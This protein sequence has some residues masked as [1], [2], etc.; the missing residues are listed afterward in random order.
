MKIRKQRSEYNFGLWYVYTEDV[1]ETTVQDKKITAFRQFCLGTLQR[2]PPG[3]V[4]HKW[5]AQ[6]Y[7]TTL[8]ESFLKQ[9]EALNYLIRFHEEHP[10]EAP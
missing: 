10:M 9:S 8:V 2:I 5:A 4:A 3:G 6:P 1:K 7:G